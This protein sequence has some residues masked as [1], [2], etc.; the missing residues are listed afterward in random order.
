MSVHFDFA[1]GKFVY[2]WQVISDDGTKYFTSDG[3]LVDK[4]NLIPSAE[5]LAFL[6]Y[7]TASVSSFRIASTGTVNYDVDW[8]DGSTETGITSNAKDHTYSTAGVY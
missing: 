2:T 3:Q 7:T 4:S 6:E 5:T 8:G 1:N